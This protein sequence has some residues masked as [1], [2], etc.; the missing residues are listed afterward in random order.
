MLA[1][2]EG[3]QRAVEGAARA[4]DRVLVGQEGRVVQPDAR[5][6]VQ[7][8]QRLFVQP[9]HHLVLRTVLHK[10][11]AQ[12]PATR[13]CEIVEPQLV[14][15]G[16]VAESRRVENG[17]RAEVLRRLETDHVPPARHAVATRHAEFALKGNEQHRLPRV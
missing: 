1:E 16:Q 2:R 15:A 6:A 9:V 3:L 11:K 8:H 17:P 7:V 12:R 10:A 4:G 13:F 14:A 5:H